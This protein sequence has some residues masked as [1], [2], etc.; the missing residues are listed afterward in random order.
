M[1]YPLEQLARML[2][3]D[4]QAPV[5]KRLYDQAYARHPKALS[6]R[7]YS[8]MISILYRQDA[9][10][11]CDEWAQRG[12]EQHPEVTSFLSMRF[13][14]AR[15]LGQ[16]Q[17]VKVAIRNMQKDPWNLAFGEMFKE[18][19]RES[20]SERIAL[21][22]ELLNQPKWFSLMPVY[23]E[24]SRSV[25]FST[26]EATFSTSPQGEHKERVAPDMLRGTQ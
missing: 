21:F 20:P 5:A 13:A 19:L 4:E 9:H 1:V 12:F 16:G 10:E 26:I 6:P 25:R 23:E 17:A 24:L 7:G 15:W 18:W 8:A 3:G 11:N 14:C 22:E 2:R